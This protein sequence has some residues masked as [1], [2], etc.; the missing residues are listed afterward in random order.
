MLTGVAVPVGTGASAN[1][2]D[3]D[4]VDGVG[5]AVVGGSAAQATNQ[6]SAPQHSNNQ[7]TTFLPS[8]D[9]R[10]CT[11]FYTGPRAKPLGAQRCCE[12]T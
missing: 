12:P 7:R 1:G 9:D 3:N 6:L 11:T 5:I 4:T 10:Y 2:I 8:A